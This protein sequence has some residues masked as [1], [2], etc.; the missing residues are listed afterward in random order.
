[1]AAPAPVQHHEMFRGILFHS[2]KKS[3][4]CDLLLTRLL[5]PFSMLRLWKYP[6]EFLAT[7]VVAVLQRP[8]AVKS[9]HD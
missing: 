6:H 4:Y 1:M 5:L 9:Q 8:A 7:I 2:P 3:S